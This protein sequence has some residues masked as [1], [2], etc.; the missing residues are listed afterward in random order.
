MRDGRFVLLRGCLIHLEDMT[1]VHQLGRID[2]ERDQQLN[3]VL[4]HEV[5]HHIHLL[6]IK[7]TDN[8]VAIGSSG[9]RQQLGDIGILSRI[10]GMHIHRDA[11]FLQ[12]IAG[13]QHTTVILHHPSA[14]A[15]DIMQGQH[16]AQ[17][18]GAVSDARIITSRTSLTSLT[19]ITR[20]ARHARTARIACTA[21]FSRI[22]NLQHGALLQFVARLLH[23]RVGLQQFLDGQVIHP[24]DTKDR[25]LTLHLMKSTDR[26][27]FLSRHHTNCH[28]EHDK[29]RKIS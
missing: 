9:I 21:S 14:V 29:Q 8:Q 26:F 23:L 22:G 2:R 4:R 24:G 10:P 16:H 7:R 13:H 15:I 12:T 1:V 5:R 25:L 28:E 18:D 3:V 11:Q 6:G 17:A 27:I 20:T 19:S